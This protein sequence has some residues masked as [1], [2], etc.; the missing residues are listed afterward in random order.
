M[1]GG[2][3]GGAAMRVAPG[4]EPQLRGPRMVTMASGEQHQLRDG[5][6]SR[7]TDRLGH[8]HQATREGRAH[9]HR[10]GWF[11]SCDCSEGWGD[12]AAV[13]E[14]LCPPLASRR[15]SQTPALVAEQRRPWART[16][17]RLPYPRLACES[18]AT[19]QDGDQMTATSWRQTCSRME[20]SL[21]VRPWA[22]G[23]AVVPP[24]GPQTRCPG[25]SAP[26]PPRGHRQAM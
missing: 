10:R 19:S 18:P 9:G 12:T 26:F 1:W 23:S 17:A 14:D 21:A 16:P 25:T 6:H 11:F 24:A 20:R 2:S 8:C 15:M 5:G 22:V 3:L 4:K 13:A 7:T